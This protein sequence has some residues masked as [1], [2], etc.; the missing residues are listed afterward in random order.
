MT[1]QPE[2]PEVEALVALTNLGPTSARWLVDA[3]VTSPEQLR[4]LG[5]IEVFRRV[6]FHRGG[7]VTFNL[8]YALE[9]ALR[10]ERWD[11]LPVALR[12]RLRKKAMRAPN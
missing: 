11:R 8:L 6:A 5:A 9:G 2:T 12:A 3:G 10:G 7:Q 4:A 1:R